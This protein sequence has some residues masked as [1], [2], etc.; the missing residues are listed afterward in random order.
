[1]R[2]WALVDENQPNHEF[3]N[4]CIFE[5]LMRKQTEHYLGQEQIE[6][7]QKLLAIQN[8]VL[9]EDLESG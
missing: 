3:L 8:Y 2:N 5:Q 4:F 1:M 6:V 9:R 7:L